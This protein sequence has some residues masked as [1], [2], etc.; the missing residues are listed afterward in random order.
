[1][2]VHLHK[3]LEPSAF[4]SQVHIVSILSKTF[5]RT[6]FSII[7]VPSSSSGYLLFI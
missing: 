5:E 7:F 6:D 1:M 3:Y 2:W 4:I